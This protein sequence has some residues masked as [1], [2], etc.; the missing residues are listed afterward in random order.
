MIELIN[1]LTVPHV[2]ECKLYCRLK[3]DSNYFLL[4]H[5][6]K[7]GTPCSQ[8]GFDKCVNGHCHQAGCDNVLY[9]AATLGEFLRSI[10][11][12]FIFRGPYSEYI[13]KVNGLVN[14]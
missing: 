12:Q 6:V 5:K 3:D 7:D 14:N 1:S 11:F 10:T 13:C 4:K 9:S 2:D 8:G